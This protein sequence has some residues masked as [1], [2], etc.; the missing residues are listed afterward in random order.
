MQEDGS[1]KILHKANL[2]GAGI[3]ALAIALPGIAH[4]ATADELTGQSSKTLQAAKSLQADFEEIDSY[5]GRYKD[6]AQRGTVSLSRP[7]LLRIDIH[8]FRRVSA[9]DPWAASGNDTTAVSDGKTYWYAFLHPNSTQVRQE[10]SSDAT[11]KSAL[12]AVPSLSA[13][14]ATDAAG[15]LPNQS[16]EATVA[17]D[18]T[19]E[20][21]SYHVVQYTADSGRDDDA[22]ARAYIGDDSIIHRLVFTTETSKGTAT[23]EWNL[24]NVSLNTP[25]PDGKFVYAPP[26]DATALDKSP[27]GEVLAEGT[28]A[29]DFAVRDAHGKLVKLSDYKGKTV[30]LDFW[31]TWCWPC[32]QSLPHTE[33]ISHSYRDKNVVTLAVAIWDSQKGFDAWIKKHNYPDI[34]FAIDPSPQGKDV[35]SALY[36]ISA[37][38][39]AYVID[40]DGK[41]AKVIAGYTGKSDALEAAIQ[42]AQQSKTASA[43]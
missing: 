24:R 25:V 43:H 19:W 37:T 6:L 30:V 42:S 36:H 10:T 17:A 23:K 1:L 39:T 8:R 29:P 11:L 16:G 3:A 38:P 18:E 15:R 41:V 28:P 22:T 31:A 32:N 26:A 21:A 40:A 5:P 9:G 4:A 27:R 7:G 13:F 34:N 14:F 2:I 20:G 33:E 35:A 12:R